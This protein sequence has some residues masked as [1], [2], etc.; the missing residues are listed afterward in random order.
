MKIV[1]QILWKWFAQSAYP[2]ITH[3]E[4]VFPMLSFLSFWST[5]STFSKQIRQHFLFPGLIESLPIMTPKSSAIAFCVYFCKPFEKMQLWW[6]CDWIMDMASFHPDINASV[7]G[8]LADFF[9]SVLT[10]LWHWYV[11]HQRCKKKQQW[12]ILKI[13]VWRSSF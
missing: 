11:Q 6:N 1:G 3:L 7:E 4:T 2:H 12:F 9:G 13:L 10:E 5:L 8:V